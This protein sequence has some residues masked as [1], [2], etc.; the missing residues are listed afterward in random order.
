VSRDDKDLIAE[1]E[2][3]LAML[4]SEVR[5]L[6]SRPSNELLAQ[7]KTAERPA[8]VS[9]PPSQVTPAITSTPPTPPRPMPRFV[10]PAVPK[11]PSRDW[12][13]IIGRY[14]TLILATVTALAAVGTFVGWA[15]ANGWLGPPQ[16]VGL[17]LLTAAALAAWGFTIRSKE[18]SFGASLIGIALA[19]VH[20]CAWGAGPSLHL[21]PT[22]V[23]FA[24]AAAAS[25]ALEAFAHREN[26]QPLW[27]VGFFGAALAP[28]VTSDGSGN[29]AMLTMYGIGVLGSGGYALGNR[30]WRIADRLFVVA[31]ALYTLALMLGPETARGPL[32]AML[33]PLGVGALGVL[34][35]SGGWKRRLRLRALGVLA[36]IASVRAGIASGLPLSSTLLSEFIAAAGVAWLGLV[37][38][39]HDSTDHEDMP[40]ASAVVSGDRLDAGVLPVAFAFSS[41]IA[42]GSHGWP[43]AHGIALAIGALV[44]LGTHVR[45]PANGLRDGAAFA[46]VTFAAV[47]TA[48]LTL[49]TPTAMFGAVALVGAAAFAADRWRSS[50]W[51]TG[52]GIVAMVWGA[53]GAFGLLAERV[54]YAYTPLLTSASASAAIVAGAFA[55]AW[56]LARD[57]ERKALTGALGTIWGFAWLHQEIVGA[58]SKTASTLLRV[59]YYAATSV[60]AVWTGRARKEPMLRHAGLALSVAAAGTALYSASG[61]ASVGA[62]ISAFLVSSGFLLGIAYWYRKPGGKAEITEPPSQPSLSGK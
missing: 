34:R 36:A 27:S 14:G 47:S 7:P 24:L 60:A 45:Y 16:R 19:I 53:I 38:L 56:K 12:E 35:W 48:F 37:Y 31:A 40:A 9:P 49:D 41:L 30:A 6:K 23:A 4:E 62:K 20:V 46:T 51:W 25:L 18:R 32:L 33:F 15:I 28:F 29:M 17:G 58:F 59:T 26:D 57:P 13:A 61:L 50:P 22:S 42:I 43:E 44:M 11:A 54:A 2:R 3:R 1:L 5:A 10:D 52:S 39:T 21:V 8:V 55:A